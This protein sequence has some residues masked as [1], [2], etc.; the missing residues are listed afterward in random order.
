VPKLRVL[1]AKQLL[2]I[3]AQFGF[4]VVSQRGSHIKLSRNVAGHK[5]TLTLP[6]HDE[7]DPGT[8]KAIMRQAGRFIS[9]EQLYPHFYSE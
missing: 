7:L 9:I 1:T 4:S 3:F 6:N 8:C 5:Q 2:V